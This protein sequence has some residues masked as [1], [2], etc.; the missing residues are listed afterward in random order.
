MRPLAVFP[1]KATIRF[2]RYAR[3][4]CAAGANGRATLE[5]FAKSEINAT[6]I[7]NHNV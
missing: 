1:F 2:R 5:Q 3:A 6:V 4:G 7:T